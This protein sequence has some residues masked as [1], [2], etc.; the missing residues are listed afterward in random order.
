[1]N[2][3]R[4]YQYRFQ[5]VSLDKKKAIWKEISKFFF[6]K[7]N[8][9]E[10]ILD[11]AGGMCE[12]INAVPA[13]EKWVIDISHTVHDFAAS[14]VKIVVGDS[15]TVEL[16]LNYF[17]A[18]FISN[19]LEHLHSQEEVADFLERTYAV[20]KPG[21]KIAIIGPNFK[22]AYREY[23]DFADHTVVLS[24][25]GVEEHLYGAGFK[26]QKSYPRFLPL[27]FRGGLPVH[28]ILVRLY[29]NMPMVWF[30]FGKQFLIIAEK[31]N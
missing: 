31:P 26:I 17:D 4:I 2:Y 7:L 18:V 16:P 29:L 24:E 19:F 14:D 13:K 23:F 8:S 11:S 1:M 20:L 28:K 3:E 25:L 27:S 12:F 15:L 21:G 6:N 30:L 9:P 5:Q 22:Y 10:R